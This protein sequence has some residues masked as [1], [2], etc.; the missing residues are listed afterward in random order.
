M[1]DPRET[2][3]I[4]R[5]HFLQ[6]AGAIAAAACAPTPVRVPPAATETPFVNPPRPPAATETPRPI[7]KGVVGEWRL[8]PL[9]FKETGGSGGKQLEVI[10]AAQNR[11]NK[12]KNILEINDRNVEFRIRTSDGFIYP[13]P[14]QEAATGLPTKFY[15]P[16]E[17]QIPYEVSISAPPTAKDMQLVMTSKAN[18]GQ[19]TTTWSVEDF[20]S[21][22]QVKLAEYF[23]KNDRGLKQLGE[24]IDGNKTL[25]TPLEVKQARNEKDKRWAFLIRGEVENRY[26]YDR[27][28]GVGFQLLSPDG[29]TWRHFVNS[30]IEDNGSQTL[31][32]GMKSVHV[33]GSSDRIEPLPDG[34]RLLTILQY[35]DANKKEPEVV[36]AVYDL[37]KIPMGTI[38]YATTIP[39]AS[40]FYNSAFGIK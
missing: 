28:I 32:P 8:S 24:P 14:Q 5:R 22:D 38:D 10:F 13:P 23:P 25:V 31:T 33:R 29:Q 9:S 27:K 3:R 17:Y 37:G 4:D 30:P 1:G 21:P 6:T 16:P 35:Y 2:L 18:S 20:P 7:E 40:G 11:S 39:G 34:T 15:I 12:L 36:W 19:Q 26:G